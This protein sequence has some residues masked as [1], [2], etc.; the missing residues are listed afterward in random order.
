[1]GKK[2]LSYIPQSYKI[3]LLDYGEAIGTNQCL[4]LPKTELNTKTAA[5]LSSGKVCGVQLDSLSKKG[6]NQRGETCNPHTY[7][8]NYGWKAET[9]HDSTKYIGGPIP[10]LTLHRSPLGG[11]CI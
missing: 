3:Q 11:G 6:L 1:M 2:I 10:L 7:I 9:P 8:F 5:Q 4:C